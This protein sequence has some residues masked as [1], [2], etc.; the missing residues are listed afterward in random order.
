MLK[1][2]WIEFFL[3]TVPEI[4]V[5]VWGIHVTSRRSINLFRY[6]FSSITLALITF[7]VRWLPINFGVHMIINMALITSIM[8][9]IEIPIVEAMSSTFLMLFILSLGEFLNTLLL[10]LLNINT[11]I[12]FINPFIKCLYYSPSLIFMLLFVIRINYYFKV[13]G[14]R[15][16][17][18]N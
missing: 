13:K 10:N 3:R 18:S 15:K 1:L 12:I 11:S 7:F 4:F 5:L 8:A 9:I 2:S 16:G 6:I 17:V 14:E